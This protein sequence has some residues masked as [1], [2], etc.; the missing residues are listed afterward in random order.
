MYEPYESPDRSK[1]VWFNR[2]QIA[3]NLGSEFSDLPEEIYFWLEGYDQETANHKIYSTLESAR[4]ALEKAKEKVALGLAS[5]TKPAPRPKKTK[6]ERLLELI[7][8]L[9]AF[10]QTLSEA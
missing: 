8:N 1:F 2:A 9:A 7:A 10:A 5:P 6:K 3:P 4:Q